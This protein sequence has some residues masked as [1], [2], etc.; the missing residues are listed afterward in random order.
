[1]FLW[2][3]LYIL[4][5]TTYPTCANTPSLSINIHSLP[6]IRYSFARGLLYKDYKDDRIIAFIKHLVVMP[7]SI[8]KFRKDRQKLKYFMIL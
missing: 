4:D 5:T 2:S 6:K 3:S 1:M 7:M 8:F